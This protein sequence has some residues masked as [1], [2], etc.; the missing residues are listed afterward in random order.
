MKK[1]QE[2]RN[3]GDK[4]KGKLKKGKNRTKGDVGKEE[5]NR[6]TDGE[7]NEIKKIYINEE[8]E[9]CDGDRRGRTRSWKW[10]KERKQ[11]REI[12]REKGKIRQKEW[13]EEEVTK[14][15]FKSIKISFR[16][17]FKIT[18]ILDTLKCL[19]CILWASIGLLMDVH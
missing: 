17:N 4:R 5:R 2:A 12:E 6:N 7:M 16:V 11:E 3:K 14:V 15:R 18:S 1:L 8:N 10:N 9:E 19:L 13:E